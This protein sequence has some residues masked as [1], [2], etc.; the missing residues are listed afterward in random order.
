MGWEKIPTL[1]KTFQ[2][3][4]KNPLYREDIEKA[5]EDAFSLEVFN[6]TQKQ[7]RDIALLEKSAQARIRKQLAIAEAAIKESDEATVPVQLHLSKSKIQGN[8]KKQ[9]IWKA[10]AEIDTNLERARDAPKNKMIFQMVKQS[11]MSTLRKQKSQIMQEMNGENIDR[12]LRLS[13]NLLYQIRLIVQNIENGSVTGARKALK[14][15]MEENT[16]NTEKIPTT[17]NNTSTGPEP[18]GKMPLKNR[19]SICYILMSLL[20][21]ISSGSI[22]T[23]TNYSSFS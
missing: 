18:T 19:P 6:D 15:L 9:K 4:V 22:I 14:K 11:L 5:F 2:N 16:G 1:H 17:A 13:F 10:L 21:I 23:S 7:D 20:T 3:E 12:A 8:P